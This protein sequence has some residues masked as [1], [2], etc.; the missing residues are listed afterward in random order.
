MF[1]IADDLLHGS[2]GNFLHPAF[3]FGTIH[4]YLLLSGGVHIFGFILATF[5]GR[6]ITLCFPLLQVGRC[7]IGKCLTGIRSFPDAMPFAIGTGLHQMGLEHSLRPSPR[8]E[9][10]IHIGKSIGHAKPFLSVGT[11]G[12]LQAAASVTVRIGKEVHL[13]RFIRHALHLC[14]HRE[15]KR[16]K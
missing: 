6:E 11:P 14:L 16:Q 7:Y 15:D 8:T 9:V 4:Q 13:I 12:K 2:I 1:G 10:G 3:F 5:F